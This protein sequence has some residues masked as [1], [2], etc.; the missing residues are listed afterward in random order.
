MKK[1]R[2]I[3]TALF[4]VL[5]LLFF[6]FAAPAKADSASVSFNTT[7]GGNAVA[8]T[9][10]FTVSSAGTLTVTVTNT[11]ANPTTVAQLI[12]DLS[13]NVSGMTGASLTSSSSTEVSISSG[14]VASLGAT[15][16]TGWTLSSSGPTLTLTAPLPGQLIIGPGGVS[17]YT[18]ANGSIAGNKPH[19]PFLNGSATFTLSVTGLTSVS[20]ISNV[21]VS[22]GTTPGVNLSV[23]PT[24]T[25]EVPSLILFGTGL[26]GLGAALRRRVV[27]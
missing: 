25:P 1:P 13:F 19:N 23:T 12:S 10:L 22:F 18:N 8:G 24:P 27:A 5:C 6:G 3:G 14:G 16:S 26:I 21:M 11:E 20:Q 7:V 4:S 15:G 17:G 2:V 9:L